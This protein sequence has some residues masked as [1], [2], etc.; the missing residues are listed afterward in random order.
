LDR[1]FRVTTIALLLAGLVALTYKII[2]P[3]LVPIAWAVIICYV[4]WPLHR[5]VRE[6]L[7][8]QRSAAAVVTTLLL[9]SVVVVP[10][11]WLMVLLQGE[12][13]D[14]IRALPEWLE[15][16]PELPAFVSRVPFFGSELQA[17]VSQFED[18]QG[19]LKQHAL[20]WFKRFGTPMIGIMTNLGRDVFFLVMTLFTLFFLFRDGRHVV[21]QVKQLLT[22]VL[23]ERL[24]GYFETTEA[25]VKAVVYGIV[26]TALAQGF[27]SGLGYWAVGVKAPIVLGIVT[28]FVAMIPFGTPFVWGSTSLWLVLHGE[29]W[30]GVALALWGALV[31]SWVDNIIR[32]LVISSS[33]RIPFVLVMFGVLGGLAS[34]GFIGLFLGPVILAMALAVWREW[35]QVHETRPTG[36]TAD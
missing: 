11:I 21:R 33:T 18:L 3:F 35:L 15:R 17:I 2:R 19:L 10:L 7:V 5:A 23:G 28:T 22:H 20:P 32:P 16:K 24:N 1:S 31:V 34:F 12:L 26:L 36:S 13:L 4:T 9:G 25:T 30:S 14:L 6:R 27:L 29:T 8:H